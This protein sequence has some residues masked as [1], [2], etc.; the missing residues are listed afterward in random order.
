MLAHPGA[1]SWS[2]V[3][4]GRVAGRRAGSGQHWEPGL[5][6]VRGPPGLAPQVLS[7]PSSSLAGHVALL[8]REQS[9]NLFTIWNQRE[10]TFPALSLSKTHSRLSRLYKKTKKKHQEVAMKTR[11]LEDTKIARPWTEK[12]L[13]CILRGVCL[14]FSVTTGKASNTAV[15]N[16]TKDAR[17]MISSGLFL[18][19][20]S[21]PR[22]S[23]KEDGG[24]MIM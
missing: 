22:S 23:T 7:A 14:I 11:L 20:D 9:H 24:C 3:L 8:A 15:P 12:Q 2:L 17:Y 21:A 13:L 16:N 19:D 10:N 1:R 4:G 18:G 5:G 6:Q